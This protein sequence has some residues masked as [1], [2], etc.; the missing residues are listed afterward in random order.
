MKVLGASDAPKFDIDDFLYPPI[1]EDVYRGNPE[2]G[3][4]A[5]CPVL[6]GPPRFGHGWK[7]GRRWQGC[8]RIGENRSVEV[9]LRDRLHAHPR[10]HSQISLPTPRHRWWWGR[11]RRLWR[12]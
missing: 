4:R 6:L 3:I 12:G 5:K 9:L 10:A 1:P 8:L 11:W 7:C 2:K